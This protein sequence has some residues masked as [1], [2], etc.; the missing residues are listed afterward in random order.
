MLHVEYARTYY[1]NL[2]IKL[3]TEEYNSNNRYNNIKFRI[4]ALKLNL[5]YKENPN[6]R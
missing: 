1:S 6:Y 4:E 3:S 5:N 2:V